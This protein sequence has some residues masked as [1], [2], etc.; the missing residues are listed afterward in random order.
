MLLGF[1][2]GV[3]RVKHPPNLSIGEG[4]EERPHSATTNRRVELNG[5]LPLAKC[6]SQSVA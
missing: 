6:R 4:M 5:R 1:A 2:A 3:V